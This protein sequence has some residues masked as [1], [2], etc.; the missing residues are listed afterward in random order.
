MIFLKK[1]R[2]IDG[3][4]SSAILLLP[5]GCK[6]FANPREQKYCRN[7]FRQFHVKFSLAIALLPRECKSFAAPREQKY[8]GTVFTSIWRIFF[9]FSNLYSN[10]VAWSPIGRLWF[11]KPLGVISSLGA[12]PLGMKFDSRGFA[13]SIAS[14]SAI[15]QYYILALELAKLLTIVHLKVGRNLNLLFNILLTIFLFQKF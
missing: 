8:C 1:F 3:K 4:T 6:S 15:T 5:R 9:L 14:R 7:F 11:C 12:S 2:Q 13:K 10:T